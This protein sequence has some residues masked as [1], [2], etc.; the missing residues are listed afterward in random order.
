MYKKIHKFSDVIS[1]FCTRDWEFTNNNVKLLLNKMNESD[2]D[3]FSF[4]IKKVLWIQYFKTYIIGI[5]QY[6]LKDPNST[7]PAAQKRQEKYTY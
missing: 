7:I 5:R 4:D 2:K 3:I 6:L 1:Y